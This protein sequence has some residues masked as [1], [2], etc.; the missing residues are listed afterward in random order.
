MSVPG[1]INLIKT[2]TSLTPEII[3]LM[4]QLRVVSFVGIGVILVVG[5]LIGIS[6][7][8]LT[9]EQRS[10]A[11]TKKQLLTVIAADAK[12][13]SLFFSLK[14]RIPVVDR[15]IQNEK[16]WGQ[17]LDMVG[18]VILPPKLI[19]LAV[20]DHQVVFFNGKA[21]SVEEVAGWTSSIIDLVAKR[22]VR[23]PQLVSLQL[24]KEGSMLVSFSFIPN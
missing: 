22:R 9:N 20:D 10:L 5:F 6:F 2:K 3:A 18:N 13:E 12:K 4:G 17:I 8:F 21:G 23:S 15:A 14:D 19:S 7:L 1:D 16:P 11:E 24:T